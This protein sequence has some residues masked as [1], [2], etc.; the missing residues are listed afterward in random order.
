[1][2]RERGK[3]LDAGVRRGFFQQVAGCLQWR[4]CISYMPSISGMWL[5]KRRE[6]FWK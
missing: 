4:G 1:M 2:E 3:G 5:E 6:F